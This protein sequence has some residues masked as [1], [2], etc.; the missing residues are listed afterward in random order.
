M[1]ALGIETSGHTGRL[2][3]CDDGRVLAEQRFSN[4]PRRARAI[5][6]AIDELVR[7]AAV[8]KNGVGLVAV[9]E[10][11][12]SFTGIRV[13]VA[14][15]KSIA[16][17][18]GWQTVGVPSL[19]V[20]A[21]NIH[22]D[23]FEGCEWTCPV[24]DARRDRVYAT[25]FRRTDA[26]WSDQTGVMLKVDFLPAADFLPVGLSRAMMRPVVPAA[27]KVAPTPIIIEDMVNF[28]FPSSI[29]CS[30]VCAE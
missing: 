30:L 3:L 18:L 12:G 28:C 26:R 2:A 21:Q 1:I 20:L 10:G 25:L 5:V 8:G 11:P 15:A 4:G 16:W 23:E 6:P 9:S 14:C 13:A 27:R 17:A 22:S 19:E 7:D 24:R 29:F